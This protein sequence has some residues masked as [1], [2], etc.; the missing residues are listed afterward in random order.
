M[1]LSSLRFKYSLVFA[2]N[3]M[4]LIVVS[5]IG[6]NVGVNTTNNLRSIENKVLPAIAA[7]LNADR[8][9][10]Q[11]RV[12]ELDMLAGDQAD[13][14]GFQA[15]YQENAQQALDR[16]LKFQALLADYPQ[17]A[18]GLES[19]QQRFQS[20]KQQS[21]EVFALNKSDPAKALELSTGASLTSFNQLRELYNTATESAEALAKEIEQRSESEVTTQLTI[22]AIIAIV[23]VGLSVIIA[24]FG[25]KIL[26]TS[27][28]Q[29]TQRITEITQG[30]GDLTQRLEVK[31]QNEMGELANS[32]NQF[33]D[34][35]EGL[36]SRVNGFSK[37]L[38]HSIAGISQKS[39]QTTEVSQEQN[40]SVEMIA[41]A[42]TEMAAAIREV[43]NNA[44]HTA[45]EI[46]TVNSQTEQGQNITKQSVE[47]ITLLSNTVQ[48]AS[49]VVENL[50]QESDR[51]ASV[52]DV[53]RGIA[54]QTNL[55]A[56]N[57]AIEAARAGEQG[58]GFAVVADE[59]RSLASKTQ[60]S[61]E[62]IQKMIEALQTGVTRAVDAIAKGS[63][64]AEGTVQLAEQTLEALN[65]ILDSTSRVSEV[66]TAT[67]TST[68]E[69]SHVTED[70]NRNLTEL[71]DKTRINLEN[72]TESLADAKQALGQAGSLNQQLQRFKVSA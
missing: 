13:F 69:Q 3:A 66:S 32:F 60:Q 46:N 20:W 50:S 71:T 68:E 44:N 57:A 70:I 10:Y 47:Q 41:T 8:D 7:V 72:A 55:L 56:L 15:D 16:M 27:I 21:S 36:I 49:Q 2:L 35:L 28:N 52:L 54:E 18:Q 67:A 64:V 58:R 9:L 63:S 45:E 25:P 53:I 38:S 40:Q 43:A 23:S 42:V 19:F 12:A 65:Q 37:E 33:V 22:L 30:D 14:Q 26:V 34:L 62:D 31:S 4:M 11:A 29:I 24:Y 59:V 6:Y 1:K 39:E 51:I 17:A 48:E 5:L 61:T